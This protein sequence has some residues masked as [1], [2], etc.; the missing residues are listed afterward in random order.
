M[1]VPAEL[2]VEL[3]GTPF[4][5]QASFVRTV[6]KHSDSPREGTHQAASSI[7]RKPGPLCPLPKI[8]LP[9]VDSVTNFFGVPGAAFGCGPAEGPLTSWPSPRQ[10]EDAAFRLAGVPSPGLNRSPGRPGAFAHTITY[11]RDRARLKMLRISCSLRSRQYRT[12][13]VTS[14]PVANNSSGCDGRPRSCRAPGSP[15]LLNSPSS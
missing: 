10:I 6:K 13:C 1:L 11:C 2:L 3:E 9:N 14:F 7:P 8:R 4:T 5:D 15:G 12:E